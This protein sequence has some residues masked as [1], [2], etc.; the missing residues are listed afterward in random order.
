MKLKRYVIEQMKQHLESTYPYEGCGVMLGK[1]NTV[2]DILRGT[3]IKQDRKEDRFVL[4]P[5]DILN[6][7]KYAKERGID[8]L[9]FY[10]SHPDHPAKPSQTDLESAWEDYYYAIASVDKGRMSKIGLFKL[11]DKGNSFIEETIN[12]ED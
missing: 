8:I 5:S 2:T 10:H 12:I 9:G 4:D 3:N 1:N 7:E 11:S 6:A